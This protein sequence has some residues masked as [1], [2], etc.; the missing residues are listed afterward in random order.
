VKHGNKKKPWCIKNYA[1]R[2]PPTLRTD[3]SEGGDILCPAENA[4]LKHI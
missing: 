4:E 1:P 3:F 2:P